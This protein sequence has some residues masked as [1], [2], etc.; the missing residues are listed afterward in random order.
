LGVKKGKT[1][2]TI[3][4]F[5]QWITTGDAASRLGKSRQGVVWMLENRKLRGARTALGWLCDP[6]DVERLRRERVRQQA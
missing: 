6:A 5:E 1:V 3:R 2:P 4:E